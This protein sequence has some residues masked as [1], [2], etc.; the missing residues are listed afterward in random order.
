MDRA[1]DIGPLNQARDWL[2]RNNPLI[3]QF[4]TSLPSYTQER[5]PSIQT[6]NPEETRPF[7]RS[8]IVVTGE[9]LDAETHDEDFHHSRLLQ[10]ADVRD[11]S[12]WVGK[13][14]PNLEALLFPC[15]Y[16]FGRGHWQVNTAGDNQTLL[17]D[18]QAKLNSVIPHFREDHYWPPYTYLRIEER[19]IMQNSN[20][21]LSAQKK[22]QYHNRVTI[23][24]LL[25]Q[26]AYGD[27]SI[28]NESITTAIPAQLRTGDT[29]FQQGLAKINA[30]METF[31]LPSLF[32]TVTFSER[33]PEYRQ[34]LRDFGSRDSL[35]S[36]RPWEAIQ[37]Y[38]QRWSNLKNELLRKPGVI[39][40][41]NLEELV[42]R[43]E[44]QLRAA[45]HTHNLLWTSEPI[46]ALIAIDFIRADL[47]DPAMEPELHR[48]V[49]ENQMHTCREG[50][51]LKRHLIGS[52]C[53]KGFPADLS[54]RTYHH[55]RELRYRYKR[56]KEEDRWVVPYS[57]KIL[58]VWQAHINVQYCCGT[59]L[60]SY[61]SKYVSKPEPKG[62]YH[63]DTRNPLN[64][65]LLARRI[66]SMENMMLL[67][68]Y[69]ILS[70]SRACEYLDTHLPEER[71]AQI[72]PVA[73]LQQEQL[74][75]E[76][77]DPF[78]HDSVEK[79]FNRPRGPEY[80]NLT[81]F[82]YAQRYQLKRGGAGSGVI[83]GYGYG[84]HRRRKV[85]LLPIFLHLDILTDLELANL[86]KDNEAA[87]YGRRSLFLSTAANATSLANGS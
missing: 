29:Y 18:A 49:L 12:S 61:V 28:L 31:G 38:H 22:S 1:Q 10:A 56:L 16:P 3:A 21:L 60:A 45:I 63:M 20:R 24:D 85:M 2:L 23:S 66:G 58:L 57:P 15:F 41:G 25:T 54:D 68:S 34:I 35:P 6:S 44:F 55:D 80:E 37:Y 36:N 19:R 69:P 51:C 59:G 7:Y 86:D 87:T 5:F 75:M 81:Y 33:W 40:F 71:S 9:Y 64:E 26:S 74:T 4:S 82:E 83:D 77:P 14:D 67:L 76:N 8:D 79:Y 70:V 42:E 52:Q 46:D 43:H 78:F 62:L 32:L 53:A 11:N 17:K 65:H 73:I 48:L 72:K 27:W 30:M 13:N 47:P 39:G 50:L 84:V